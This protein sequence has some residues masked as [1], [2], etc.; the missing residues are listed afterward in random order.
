[1]RPRS[2]FVLIAVAVIVGCGI[3]GVKRAPIET[4]PEDADPEVKMDM[5]EKM[6]AEYKMLA[7]SEDDEDD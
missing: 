5:L 3:W 6:K 4:V 7:K 1:M 2:V